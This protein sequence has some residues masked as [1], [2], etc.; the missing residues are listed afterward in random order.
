MTFDEFLETIESE[1]ETI[2]C[3]LCVPY[4]RRMYTNSSGF[5][6][7]T[8]SEDL[9]QRKVVRSF[10]GNRADPTEAYELDCGHTVI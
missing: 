9:P 1:P 5:V 4:E 8:K 10:V 3:Y 7:L 6:C 2:G